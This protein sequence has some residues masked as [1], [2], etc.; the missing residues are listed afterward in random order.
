MT[1]NLLFAIGLLGMTLSL[2]AETIV[3]GG[4]VSGEWNLAGSPYLIQGNI[5]IPFSEALRIGAGVEVIFLGYTDSKCSLRS[6]YF[7]FYGADVPLLDSEHYG[8][9]ASC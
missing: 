8:K 7:R 4:D 3:P 5:Q 9:R 1:R 2:Q 6:D